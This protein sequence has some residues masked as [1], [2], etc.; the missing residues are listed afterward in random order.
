MV[1]YDRYR[2]R[3]FFNQIKLLLKGKDPDWRICVDILSTK[4][5]GLLRDMVGINGANITK[6]KD[7][8]TTSI[9]L[10]DILRMDKTDIKDAFYYCFDDD[11][12]NLFQYAFSSKPHCLNI[13]NYVAHSF[14]LP[15]DYTIRNALIVFLSIVR[16]AKFNKKD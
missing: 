11:D 8:N 2:F 3:E 13:R 1:V 7:G 16:L 6:F 10:E 12:L 9:V 4:F 14:Y 15:S 5:E